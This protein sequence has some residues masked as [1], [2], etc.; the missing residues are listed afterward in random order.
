MTLWPSTL[1]QI[2]QVC[3][4]A[5]GSFLSW[6]CYFSR[7]YYSWPKQSS[8]GTWLE[9]SKIGNTNLYLPRISGILSSIH[10]KLLQDRQADDQDLREGCQDQIGSAMWWGISHLEEAS[11][12]CTYV[13][14]TWHRETVWCVLWCIWYGYW[15]CNNAGW[16]CNYLC[17][18]AARTLYR[19]LPHPWSRSFSLPVVI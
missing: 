13:G 7:G 6:S 8:R 2:Q 18:T 5:K 15:R 16:P 4:L 9:V 19:A 10:S 17:F 14:S 12:H 3:I 11:H 1:C